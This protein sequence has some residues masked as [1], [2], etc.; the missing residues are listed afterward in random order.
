MSVSRCQALEAIAVATSKEIAL[1]GSAGGDIAVGDALLFVD[2][3]A[4]IR[5]GGESHPPLGPYS[6]TM[7]RAV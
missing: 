1:I 2:A 7:R 3:V 5:A 4:V 6:R